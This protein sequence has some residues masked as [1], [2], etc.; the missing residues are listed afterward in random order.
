MATRI[1]FIRHGQT[2]EN[3]RRLMQ[4]AQPTELTLL[5]KI[6]A[7]AAG[8]ALKVFT[9][10]ALYSSTYVRARQT[11]DIISAELGLPVS[12]NTRLREQG[13]GEWEGKSWPAIAAADPSIVERRHSEGWWFCPP[14]GEPRLRVRHRMLA[15]IE[16]MRQSHPDT[17][18]A[19][20][21]HGG[22]LYFLIN[23]LLDRVPL[24]RAKL[25]TTN[26][27]LTV[28][29]T[30]EERAMLMSLNEIQ[31]LQGLSAE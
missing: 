10:T 27:G 6:Q 14:G 23:A 16:D 4:G 11:A 18:I 20:V 29:D 2:N 26:C 13:L 24:G 7:A 3:E 17:A 21:T 5:G 25:H 15:F 19:A 9:P 30:D 31:H 8:R 28:V 1:I 12:E 22:A